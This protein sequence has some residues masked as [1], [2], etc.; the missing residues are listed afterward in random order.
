MTKKKKI[1]PAKLAQRVAAGSVTSA[2]K[3]RAARKNGKLGG[4]PGNPEI[5]RIQKQL[6]VTRQRA[7]VIWKQRPK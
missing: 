1:S 6:G 7:W 3:A 5:K 2:S 4:R